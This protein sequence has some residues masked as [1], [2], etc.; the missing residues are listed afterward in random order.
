MTITH[1]NHDSDGCEGR[2]SARRLL[3]TS[4]LAALLLAACTSPTVKTNTDNP[5]AGGGGG[6]GAG[7]NSGFDGPSVMFGE[8]G[9][10]MRH[11]NTAPC[12]GLQCQQ[13]NCETGVCQQ[14]P[15]PGGGK[16]TLRGKVFDPAGK[17]PLYNVLVYVPN[18]PIDPI[19]TGPSCDRCDKPVSGKPVS[20]AMTD[21]KGSFVMDNVPVGSNIPLVIQVGKWRRVISL[22]PTTACAETVFEDP[23]V[24]RLPRKQSEGNIPKIALTTG[25]ADRLECFLRKIGIDESEFTPEAG[26]GRINLFAGHQAGLLGG[27]MGSTNAYAPTLNGGAM[28]TPAMTFWN[29]PAAF[30]RYDMVILSC[31]GNQ[32]L[33][34]K[35]V[36]ARDNLVAYA[37]AGGR[38]FASHWHN[39]WLEHA[40]A[41]APVSTWA[42]NQNLNNI[43]T[44]VDTSFP[45]GDALADWLVNVGASMTKGQLPLVEAKKTVGAI[46][47]MLSRRWIH[48][49]TT[50]ATT[51]QYFTFN[52]PVAAEMGK[53]CGRVVFTDIHVSAGDMAGPPYPMGCLTTDLSPQEKALLFL[54]FDLSSCL[55]PDDKPRPPIIP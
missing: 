22:P 31:E 36:A 15:C 3:C 49:T 18:A 2:A 51:T 41:W 8:V 48:S 43:T 55:Q 1:R 14:K 20:W 50:L 53:E 16:T 25:G 42:G 39:A 11:G 5:G 34:E 17:N 27:G 23:Q 28:L 47:P 21:T 19:E 52:T 29:D 30:K 33:Q 44:E 13:T 35:S 54:L 24:M 26:Q 7:G 46:N 40:P 9:M 38:V 6:P 10:E 4:A 32:Y 12:E 45:K 37:N